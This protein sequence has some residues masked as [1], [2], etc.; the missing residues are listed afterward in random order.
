MKESNHHHGTQ[1][2]TMRHH[3]LTE[4]TLTRC[5]ETRF[6]LSTLHL[7]DSIV[8]GKSSHIIWPD[9]PHLSCLRDRQMI[10]GPST[11]CIP[12]SC[13]LIIIAAG[14]KGDPLWRNSYGVVRIK[15]GFERRR[16]QHQ[17]KHYKKSQRRMHSRNRSV[18]PR[19][20]SA[21]HSNPAISALCK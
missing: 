17:E 1:K 4:R 3:T 7:T 18:L 13:E 15:K 19:A 12:L 8:L 10:A 6:L 20:F 14:A 11:S 9:F 16:W 21:H 5:Q 2:T